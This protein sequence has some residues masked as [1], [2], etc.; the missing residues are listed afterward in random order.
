MECSPKA[1]LAGLIVIMLI[2]C[3]FVALPGCDRTEREMEGLRIRYA[4]TYVYEDESLV[5]T[6]ELGADGT[7]KTELKIDGDVSRT[8]TGDW[9]VIYAFEG[10]RVT[11]VDSDLPELR[12]TG[13]GDLVDEAGMVHVRQ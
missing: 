9:E 10:E 11:F 2:L 4:G 12:W 6:I 7:Y 5:Y 13:D 1:I 8:L 3:T